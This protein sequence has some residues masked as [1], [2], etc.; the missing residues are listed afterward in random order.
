MTVLSA[1][2]GPGRRLVFHS[3]WW[4]RAH[5]GRAF[6]VV[7]IRQGDEPPDRADDPRRAR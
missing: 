6:E 5:W 7:S 4:L 3:E 2:D 1:L